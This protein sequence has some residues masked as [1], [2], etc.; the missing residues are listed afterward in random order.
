MWHSPGAKWSDVVHKA[1][2]ALREFRIGGVATNIPFLSAVLAHPDFV[3]NRI[4][5]GLSTGTSP[6]LSGP[7]R[8]GPIRYTLKQTGQP[9]R[10]RRL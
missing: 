5:T 6:R 9:Q 1:A 3:V 8:N 4:S 2:R 10:G 7:R